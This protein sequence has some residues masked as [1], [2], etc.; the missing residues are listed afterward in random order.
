[1]DNPETCETLGNP[2]TCETLGNPETCE[3]LGKQDT[4]KKNNHITWKW[5]H[6]N[7][8]WTY[9]RNTQYLN[10]HCVSLEIQWVNL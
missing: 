7:S 5:Y 3:T 2:E 9:K 6:E 1:M 8:G 4:A 10:T